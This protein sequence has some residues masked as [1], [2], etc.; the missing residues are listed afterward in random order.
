VGKDLRSSFFQYGIDPSCPSRKR[1]SPEDFIIT[2]VITLYRRTAPVFTGP[3][4]FRLC[5][6]TAFISACPPVLPY[7][8]CE[9][10]S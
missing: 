7:S 4:V 1:S 10:S 3:M 6:F 5:H 9:G 8:P 2:G